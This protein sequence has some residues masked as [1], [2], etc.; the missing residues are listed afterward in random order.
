[1][2]KGNNVCFTRYYRDDL[3]S[4]LKGCVIIFNLVT[5]SIISEV[6]P[7]VDRDI[8]IILQFDE[9]Y[10]VIIELVYPVIL[11]TVDIIIRM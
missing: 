10:V 1:M 9:S 2:R 8:Y 6:L 4:D 7:Y 3:D 5:F 11:F